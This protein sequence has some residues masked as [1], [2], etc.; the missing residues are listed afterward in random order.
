MIS[1]GGENMKK[2]LS[3]T[4]FAILFLFA[5]LTLMSGCIS[6]KK[7]QELIAENRRFVAEN[8]E[9]HADL[10]LAEKQVAELESEISG[11]M[12]LSEDLKALRERELT[13]VKKT[14]TELVK[15]LNNELETGKI[16]VE[17][18]RGR[19]SMSVAEELFF[20]TGEA[21]IKPEGEEVLKQIGIILKGIPEKNIRI[22]GHT[23]NLPIGKILQEKYPT[24]WELGSA[25]AVNVARFLQNNAHIDP[26]R[27]SA[28][29][30]AQ[31]RPVASNRTR[32]G[33][34]KNRRIEIILIDRDLDLAKRMKQNLA[35]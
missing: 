8:Q 4:F 15:T 14:Y 35:S 33:R 7:F 24:N 28:V 11:L 9:L 6:N 21:E 16:A 26:L 31:Y 30:Y 18:L 32:A 34:A 25:R 19:L 1:Q 23:D 5:L 22:E 10:S 12:I 13:I 3:C 27:L 17:Q 2:S 29:S 20:D